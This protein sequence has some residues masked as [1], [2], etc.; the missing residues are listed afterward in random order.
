M[1]K[2]KSQAGNELKRLKEVIS[3]DSQ[4]N[5]IND[6]DI[7]LERILTESRK[8]VNA[9]AGSIYEKRG[10]S[11][12][13]NFAQND[14]IQKELPQ[15]KK[16]IY[17]FF[18][19]PINKNTISGYVAKTRELL[20]IKNAYKIP[21]DSPYSHNT[22]YD[23][24]SGYKTSSMLTIPLQNSG[25]EL[26][27]VI[28]IINKKSKNGRVIPFS[29]QDELVVTHFATN[30]SVALERA[31]ITRAISLRMISMAELR[32]PKET[33]M[34]VIRVA[35][36]STEIYEKW[37][38]KKGIDEDKIQKARDDLRIAA[39]LHDVGKVAISDLILKKPARFTPEEYEIMKT[40]T[41]HG[42]RLFKE[43]QSSI[44]QMAIEIALNH[45]ENWDGTGYPG[46]VDIFTGKPLGRRRKITGKKGKEIPL[47]GRIVA[48][49]D[50]YDALR[51]KRV[52]KSAWKEEDVLNEIKKMRGKKFD[53]ELTDA[54][55]EVLP[56]I[57]S[58]ASRYV[59][60]DE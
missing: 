7:L 12:A 52:Y 29:K 22:M 16:L 47:W 14:T 57:Q 24:K 28:Q 44:D 1:G 30:A 3:F 4:L 55:F 9:D 36:F 45:H 58:I 35:G 25:R 11:L 40:H 33:G 6:M 17:K 56:N 41:L 37:A 31:R 48:I 46:H 50:V 34:H 49:A 32:D 20:N 13:I 15:G 23:E 27:G 42:A 19:L 21:K 10:N 53:P 2:K 59:D 26:L 51:S 5:K 38:R 60:E 43:K 54:F 8:L 18:K 39:M